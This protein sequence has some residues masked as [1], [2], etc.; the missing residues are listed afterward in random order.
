MLNKIILHSLCCLSK[1]LIC[2]AFY[3]ALAKFGL[4]MCLAMC[5]SV[6]AVLSVYVIVHNYACLCV[7]VLLRYNV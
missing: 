3:L 7:P 6:C 2:I 5:M 1:I 4:S